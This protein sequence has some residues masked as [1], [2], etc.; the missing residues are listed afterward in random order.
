M[1]TA[2]HHPSTE[3]LKSRLKVSAYDSVSSLLL[4]ALVMVSGAVLL[5]F[6]IWLTTVLIWT[7]PSIPVEFIEYEGRGDHAEGFE[8]DPE[9]PGLEDLPEVAEPTLQT[10]LEAVTDVLSTQAAAFDPTSTNVGVMGKGGGMG[11][12]RQP[13]PLG[14]GRQ[15]V[16]P[17][18]RWEIRFTSSSIEEYRKQLDFFKIEVAAFGGSPQIDYIFNV[19]KK[20]PDKRAQTNPKDEQRVRFTWKGGVLLGY[21]KQLLGE[22]A[23]RTSGRVVCQFYPKE[24]YDDLHRLEFQSGREPE[25]WLRTVFGVRKGGGG[26]EFFIIQQLF[27]PAPPKRT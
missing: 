17:W 10:S 27:R 18:E 4:A 15:V 6:L 8:F 21:D 26:Y 13:G 22:A 24:V 1:T 12:R 7:K 25:E 23:I 14:K 11:D 16:P 5:M 3:E 2:S 19:A 20:P 9:P